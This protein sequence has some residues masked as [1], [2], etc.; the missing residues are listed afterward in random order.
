[1]TE[2]ELEKLIPFEMDLLLAL[3]YRVSDFLQ[4]HFD[5]HNLIFFDKVFLEEF[6]HFFRGH[7]HLQ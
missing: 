2:E 1:M 7:D 4:G 5:P 3:I 6:T